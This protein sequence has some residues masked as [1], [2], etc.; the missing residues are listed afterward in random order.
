M[1]GDSSGLRRAD[2]IAAALVL[3]ALTHASSALAKSPFGIATPDTTGPAFSGPLGGFFAWVALYQAEFYRALTDALAAIKT[4]GHAFLWLAGLSF[5]YGVFHAVGPGHGKA[6][7]TSYLLVSRQTIRRAMVIT[8]AASAMQGG[9]AIALVLVVAVI[10]RAT[11]VQMTRAT[12]WFEVLSYAL[13]AAVGA[14]LLWSRTFG[15][16]H[17]HHHHDSPALALAQPAGAAG[18]G[19]AAYRDAHD[20]QLLEGCSQRPDHGR[21]HGGVDHGACSSAGEHR[22]QAGGH[23][24]APDPRSLARPLTFSRAWAAVLAVGIRPC[25]GAIIVLV[26]AL[27]QKLLLAGIGSVMAMSLGTFITVSLIAILTV[28]AK[29]LALRLAGLDTAASERV[30]HM[31]EVGGAA[32]ILLFG[33]TLLGGA[34]QAGT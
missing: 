27:S 20:R 16:G 5:L 33:L 25:S 31:V 24:H 12:D 3:L 18:A 23:S 14:W 19:L 6:V 15:G 13:I 28:S 29:D 2:G 7:I 30:M 10:L 11:A 22:H 8:F 1:R 34:L 21:D 17:R 4:S 32:V 26:F 9:V